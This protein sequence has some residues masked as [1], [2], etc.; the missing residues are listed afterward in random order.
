MTQPDAN[1]PTSMILGSCARPAPRRWARHDASSVDIIAEISTGQV[2]ARLVPAT[3][4]ISAVSLIGGEPGPGES[5][6]IRGRRS[7]HMDRQAKGTRQRGFPGERPV[8]NGRRVRRNAVEPSDRGDVVPRNGLTRR[9]GEP[10][11]AGHPS[12]TTRSRIVMA[13]GSGVARTAQRARIRIGDSARH[14]ALVPP[15]QKRFGVF[16]RLAT[17]VWA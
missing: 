4:L 8:G 9:L 1:Q 6:G 14:R 11:N 10:P 5:P 15:G 2:D 17:R 16:R 3:V 12:A 13:R 7:R